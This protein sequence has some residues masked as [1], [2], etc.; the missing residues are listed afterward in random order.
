MSS[1]FVP[2]PFTQTPHYKVE[3]I[4]AEGYVQFRSAL[5]TANMAQAAY[6]GDPLAMLS[7]TLALREFIVTR[8][9]VHFQC[10]SAE[11]LEELDAHVARLRRVIAERE[12]RVS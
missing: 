4:R 12:R 8:F 10:D 11:V 6:A 2:V 7:S 3:R 9:N 1:E 5:L